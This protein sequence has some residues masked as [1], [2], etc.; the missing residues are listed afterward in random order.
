MDPKRRGSNFW[1]GMVDTW[2]DF[3]SNLSWKLGN[4]EDIRFWM[5]DQLNGVNSLANYSTNPITNDDSNL[6]IRHFICYNGEWNWNLL[7]NHLP[8]DIIQKLEGFPPPSILHEDD[9]FTWGASPDGS[10]TTKSA[11]QTQMG[12]SNIPSRTNFDYIW[13]WKGN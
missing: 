1:N 6:S 8:R 12:Q 10:F 9:V 2:E 13:K 4:G 3:R 7:S 5:D 11:Y